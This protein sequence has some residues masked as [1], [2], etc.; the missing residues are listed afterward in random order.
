[1][2][3]I[4]ARLGHPRRLGRQDPPCASIGTCGMRPDG[5]A[6]TAYA[7]HTRRP[8]DNSREPRAI[9]RQDPQPVYLEAPRSSRRSRNSA[10][11]SET[12]SLSGSRPSEL[13]DDSSASEVRRAVDPSTFSSS[14]FV[15][16]A[17][18]LIW[19]DLVLSA[20]VRD[21]S[22]RSAPPRVPPSLL[23]A[24]ATRVSARCPEMAD[25][26]LEKNRADGKNSCFLFVSFTG[27]LASSLAG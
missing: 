22:I 27:W 1:M 4:T 3:C 9:A 7:T 14:P 17:P 15:S 2:G 18:L 25:T 11:V 19:E 24:S 5:N 6:V 12:H 21:T 13:A 20:P 26:V 10:A 8:R 23:F 16:S